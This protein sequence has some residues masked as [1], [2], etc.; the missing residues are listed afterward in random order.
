MQTKQMSY[1]ALMCAVI[2]VSTLWFKFTIP[3]TDV[4]VTTQV[5]FVLITGHLLPPA[6]AFGT[7]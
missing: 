6:Y 2:I 7:L 4:M 1:A 3:G 5:F